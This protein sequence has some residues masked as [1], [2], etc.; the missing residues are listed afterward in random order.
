M[1]TQLLKI[2]N[3]DRD[4][5]KINLAAEILRNGGLAVLPTETVYGIAANALDEKAVANI[6]K[7][8]GR[9]SDNPLIVHV[10]NLEQVY[11]LVAEF[12][13][14]ARRLAKNF[15]P[16]PL[17]IVL[18]KSDKIPYIVSAGLNTVAVRMPA[19]P[20][21]A[22]V[23]RASGL[24]LAA[25][26]ANLSG[27]PSPTTAA[28][29]IEDLN[30][31]VDLILDGGD[32]TVG[33]ESTVITLA[34]DTPRLL[35]P[36]MVTL[37]QLQAVL[38]TVVC[39]AA[40]TSHTEP[41]GKVHSP[42]M[43]YK[44]YAP[45]ASIT[46]VHGDFESFA[47]FMETKR[48]SIALVFDGE[49][50]NLPVP[51]V[52][53][54]SRKNPEEQAKRLFASLR[55][56]DEIG[57]QN[58]YARA[59]ERDGASLAVY[60]RLIRACAFCEI[61]LREITPQL[62]VSK[63]MEE[64]TRQQRIIGLTGQT[65]AGK[66]TVCDLLRGRGYKIID[67]DAIARKVVEKGGQ[68]LLDLA[69]EF[70]I[71]I[72]NEDG[73]LN[74]KKLAEIAFPDREKRT[75][76]N[77]ITHPYILAEIRAQTEKLFKNG[78]TFVFLDA[79]TLLESGGDA[80]CDKVVSVVAPKKLRMERI[81]ARDGLTEEEAKARISA[82]HGDTFYSCRSDYTIRNTSSMS[83][84]RLLVMEMLEEIGIVS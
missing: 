68:C 64:T 81:I 17:T 4:T 3:P 26:S 19:H 24:P 37:E 61:D 65:G 52:T 25:P 53:Y 12:P 59:P 21:M 71:E 82:Q 56:L 83:A 69:I 75:R 16:G 58:V 38:G 84:L 23:I 79:P 63:N 33:V 67:A 43:K 78:T 62:G 29:C 45:A 39:D 31:K 70:T 9:P 76:L 15:W 6:F 51:C 48:G 30:G 46:L 72:L 40:V 20:V 77:Q 13:E 11:D 2:H 22:A 14:Q 41:T 57:A 54:G 55:K 42:G 8:K 50:Q 32:C 36:G 74:R 44:H 28:H 47:Q 7:V 73:T 5:D 27:K 80:M 10:S 1:K 49:E 18:P 60:N 66:S 34:D 35:R